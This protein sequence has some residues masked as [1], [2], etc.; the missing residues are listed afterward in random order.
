M[1]WNNYKWAG[2]RRGVNPTEQLVCLRLADEANGRGV[3]DKLSHH[4]L[5]R[6]IPGV[7][8]RRLR[9]VIRVLHT[10]KGLIKARIARTGAKGQQ[11]SNS[12]ELNLRQFHPKDDTGARLWKELL[13][14][15]AVHELRQPARF[16]AEGSSAYYTVEFKLLSV[17][18][19]SKH[20]LRFFES[21]RPGTYTATKLGSFTPSISRLEFILPGY[22]S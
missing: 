21:Q 5:Q 2:N 18:V 14:V 4:G 16:H 20:A 10:E 7:S 9:E 11:V 15:L 3:V 6:R 1:G 22:E 13:D 12:Y 8:R 19:E 17:F